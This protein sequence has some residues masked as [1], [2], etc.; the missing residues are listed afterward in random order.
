M[1][2]NRNK[3]IRLCGIGVLIMVM[4]SLGACGG[5]KFNA[6]VIEPGLLRF[7]NEAIEGNLTYNELGVLESGTLIIKEQKEFEKVF[8]D[9]NIDIEQEMLLVHMFTSPHSRPCKIRS[10]KLDDGILKIDFKM[11]DGKLGY[12]DA[13]NPQ[14]RIFIVKMK[15]LEIVAVE[16]N[17]V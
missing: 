12:G 3:L 7:G 11:K 10:I 13:S 4:L 16:F 8:C 9:F 15:K 1:K 14:L 17:L 6:V 5:N 2:R